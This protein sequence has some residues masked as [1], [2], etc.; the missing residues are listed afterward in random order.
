MKKVKL[1]AEGRSEIGTCACKRLRKSGM[2]PAVIYGSN[3]EE[4]LKISKHEFRRFTREVGDRACIVELIYSD[5][6]KLAMIKATQRNAL[7][8]G[9]DHVD[10]R[11]VLA[12]EPINTSLPIHLVGESAGVK[13]GGMLEVILHNVEVECLPENLPEFIEIDVSNLNV[14]EAVHIKSL[15]C[16]KGVRYLQP[17]DTVVVACSSSEEEVDDKSAAS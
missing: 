15:P 7:S 6:S 10:F 11:E 4:N 14:G 9:F 2:I 5:K 17:K 13:L 8:D 12:D 16:A 3:G 1:V